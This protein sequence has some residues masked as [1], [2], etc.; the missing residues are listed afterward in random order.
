MRC[1]NEGCEGTM[2]VRDRFCPRC[3]GPN[4]LHRAEE[5]Q[6]ALP[7]DQSAPIGARQ[8]DALQERVSARSAPFQP[9]A[10][11]GQSYPALRRLAGLLV[12]SGSI[13]RWVAVG[14]GVLALIASLARGLTLINIALGLAGLA[15]CCAVGWLVWLSLAVSAELVYLL[16][17]VTNVF[18]SSQHRRE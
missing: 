1:T 10:H 3:G 17:D 2:A 11:Q 18:C 6:R 15:T 7:P 13:M 8:A 14:L 4:P 9:V 12:A 16:L 5:P